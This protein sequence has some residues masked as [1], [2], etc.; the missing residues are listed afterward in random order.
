MPTMMREH[1]PPALARLDAEER[2]DGR[3]DDRDDREAQAGEALVLLLRSCDAS[4]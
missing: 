2:H 4:P 3:A 1:E